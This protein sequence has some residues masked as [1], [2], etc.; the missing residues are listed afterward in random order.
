MTHLTRYTRITLISLAA[1]YALGLVALTLLW[2]R[3]V[4]T[5][6]PLAVANIFAAYLFLP[7]LPSL[8]LALWLRSRRFWTALMVP[9]ALWLV[10]FGHYLLPPRVAAAEPGLRL[11][12]MNLLYNNERYFEAVEY[13]RQQQADVVL[14]QELSPEM[15]QA[16]EQGLAQSYPYR[17]LRPADNW[18]GLGILSRY[19]FEQ[20]LIDDIS[21]Q[22]LVIDVN[23][24]RLRLMHVHPRA[25]RLRIRNVRRWPVPQSFS[26][27]QR[28]EFLRWLNNHIDQSGSVANGLIVAGD[29]NL[30]DREE[31]YRALDERLDNAF[32][33]AG[34]GFGA[35]FPAQSA[36]TPRWIPFP[37][38][39]IDHVWSSA[40]LPAQHAETHCDVPGA[41]HCALVVELG[42]NTHN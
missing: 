39:R 36:D 37:L 16:L 25:P 15:A 38:I 33:T 3:G 23:G 12:T 6:W 20:L 32:D 22:D 13:I 4:T 28:D 9:M 17:V 26:T 11:L 2:A 41:D 24:Q 14:V 21:L 31:P 10:L 29:F 34:W 7:V 1:L 42:L 40:N 30:T 19:P 5:P 8:L 35:T 27:E 18:N